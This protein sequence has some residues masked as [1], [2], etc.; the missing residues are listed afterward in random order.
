MEKN[1]NLL[2]VNFTY[3]ARIFEQKQIGGEECEYL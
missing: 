1:A 3:K 2:P